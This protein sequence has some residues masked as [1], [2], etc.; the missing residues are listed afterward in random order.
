MRTISFFLSV[1]WFVLCKDKEEPR[2][3]YVICMYV[4]VCVLKQ[5]QLL[6]MKCTSKYK[7]PE[8]ERVTFSHWPYGRL[9]QTLRH[10]LV[11]HTLLSCGHDQKHS[12][13]LPHT[14][15]LLCGE[16]F[17]ILCVL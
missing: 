8:K 9:V 6:Q 17:N 5:K 15:A 4:C 2:R 14:F 3:N 13:E 11:P 7:R 1:L 12:F 10:L 16:L